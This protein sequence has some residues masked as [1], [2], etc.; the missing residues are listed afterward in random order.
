MV[1]KIS[2]VVTDYVSGVSLTS[3]SLALSFK[4]D[5]FYAP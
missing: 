5:I 3:A 1:D 4:R 2:S